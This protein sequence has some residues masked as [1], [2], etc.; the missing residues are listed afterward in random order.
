MMVV[1]RYA[2]VR[3]ESPDCSPDTNRDKGGGAQT[4]CERRRTVESRAILVTRSPFIT[5]A[6]RHF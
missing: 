4:N 1:L 6:L 2:V 5:G 3:I